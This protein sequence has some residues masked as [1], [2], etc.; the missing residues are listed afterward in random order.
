MEF[1][2]QKSIFLCLTMLR[3]VLGKAKLLNSLR[4]FMI[5]DILL[6]SCRR[7]VT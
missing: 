1:S 4:R 2:E 3:L 6:G 7:M 5:Y